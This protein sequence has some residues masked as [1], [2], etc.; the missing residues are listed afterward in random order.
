MEKPKIYKLDF[1]GRE[2][3]IKLTNWADQANGSA[4]IQYG[5]T[6]ILSTATMSKKPRE[7]MC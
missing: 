6:V 2:F 5:D 1:G 3:S 4:V 7:G